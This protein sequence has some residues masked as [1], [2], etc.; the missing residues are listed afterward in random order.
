MSWQRKEV[1]WFILHNWFNMYYKH[2]KVQDDKTCRKVLL[3]AERYTWNCVPGCDPPGSSVSS[4]ALSIQRRF[5]PSAVAPLAEWWK[6]TTDTFH[7]DH[8][9]TR[10]CAKALWKRD[11]WSQRHRFET[12]TVWGQVQGP[13]VFCRDG[14]PLCVRASIYVTLE[15]DFTPDTGFFI[16]K[17]WYL[18]RDNRKF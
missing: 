17:L 11:S 18:A 1:K 15:E 3:S 5:V 14:L 13:C 4:K 10:V 6:C 9:Y 8:C 16:F 7:P 12:C 2:R